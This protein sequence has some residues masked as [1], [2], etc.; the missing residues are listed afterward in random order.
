M[1]EN[2][3]H[4]LAAKCKIRPEIPLIVAVSGGPDSLSL[5]D[6]LHRLEY[7]LII[8]HFD[9]SL[10]PDS[11][12][13]AEIVRGIASQ[14]DLQFIYGK[15]DVR[16]Y[17][18]QNK[19]SIE[20]AARHTRYKFLIQQSKSFGA[21][22]VAVGH[23]SD[24]QVETILMHF[25]RGSGLD[26]LRGMPYRSL[27]NA[28]SERIP[29][30]R[31]ILELSRKQIIAYNESR[32]LTPTTDHS[33][34]DTTF[35]RNRLRYELIPNLESY[36][37]QIKRSILRMANTIQEDYWIIENTI[38]SEWENTVLEIDT[39]Y[40]ALN[41]P[42]LRVQPLGMMR[43]LIRRAVNHICPGLRDIDYD[44]V[45][46]ATDFIQTPSHSGQ[47][48]LISNLYLLIEGD[49]L[50]ISKWSAELPLFIW[51]QLQNDEEQDLQ[52]PGF[53]YLSNN[54]RFEVRTYSDPEYCVEQAQNNEDLF[55]VWLDGDKLKSPLTIRSRRPGD[56]IQPFGMHGH[57]I[58]ISDM[59]VNLKLPRR[60]RRNWPLLI[61][62]Q[63]IIWVPGSR[64][65]HKFHIGS[66]TQSVINIVL[67]R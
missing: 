46:R 12:S 58:K 67:S 23:T 11:G 13:E 32:N 47:V 3:K 18:D 15:E 26:G 20:E 39:D 8:A 10:R 27:P 37:P 21:Q 28:W 45:Q 65:A 50:W 59:M 22:A 52:V 6:I 53:N 31:P 44:A 35:F 36:N 1:I 33:N 64:I 29:I 24:D 4:I 34:L 2:I 55:K 7:R 9:H 41:F 61:S 49:R 63:D 25:L 56:R 5:L 62:G 14:M 30:I 60:A 51:P 38:G 19:L 48:D 54:W 66:D 16:R 43:R 57:S 42:Y 17:S 40:I